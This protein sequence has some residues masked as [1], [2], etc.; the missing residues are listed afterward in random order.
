M[1]LNKC[2]ALTIRKIRTYKSVK[3]LRVSIDETTD[4]SG[5]Y[6]KRNNRHISD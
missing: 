3:K 6:V 5:R 2:Q 4:V 1:Y